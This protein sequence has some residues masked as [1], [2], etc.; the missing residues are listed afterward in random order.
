MSKIPMLAALCLATPL[1]GGCII[2]DGDDD[3]RISVDYEYGGGSVY[4]AD[5][6]TDRVV[7]RVTS[8]GCTD[9]SYMDL[10]VDREDGAYVLELERDRTDDCQAIVPNGVELTWT[11]DDL[12]IPGGAHVRVSNP[13]VRR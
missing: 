10:D 5:L 6:L 9:K 12:G 4:G 11:F 7:Y 8:N 1:L 13:V 2:I 3:G